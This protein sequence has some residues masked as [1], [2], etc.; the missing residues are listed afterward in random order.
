MMRNS[1]VK[2]ARCIGSSLASAARRPC[3][4]VGHDHLAHR[5]DAVGLEE[6]VLGARQADSL[7]AEPARGA[8]IDRGLGIG[9]DPEGAD[10]VGPAHQC[11]EITR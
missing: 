1:S 11:R 4:L 8:G 2:S 9:A 3:F 7:G 6:H 5:A 10:F